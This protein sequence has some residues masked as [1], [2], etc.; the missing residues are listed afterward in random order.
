[1]DQELVAQ[2][3]TSFAQHGGQYLGGQTINSMAWDGA[4]QVVT[5]LG[6][7]QIIKSEKLLV[8][9]GR[10]ANVEDL[11]LTAAG[12]QL[13][14]K[15]SLSVNQYCQTDAPHIY[16]AGDMVGA[17]A[18]ASK[19]MEQG[20][21][22][23]RHALNLPIG[24]A[25]STIPLGI[26]T[27]PEM[28]SIGMDEKAAG[29][30]YRNP[31]VGR[32]K[33]EEIARAQISGSS[34]GLL[35]MIADPR[36]ERLLGIQIVGESATELI[37]LGQMALQQGAMIESFINSVFNFPTYAEAYRVAALDILGQAAKRDTA[38]AA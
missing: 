24:D 22:S 16:A 20:R 28:A 10:Q 13:N 21:R 17:P 32:A 3:T 2:F 18:L 34:D 14:A 5:I 9:L 4:T 25:L 7:G 33:F 23:V 37:H 1:M 15:G 29:E 36:G 26:Y 6:D 19:A 27:I 30:R 35:K 12:L 31:I 38:A 8:A 11:N